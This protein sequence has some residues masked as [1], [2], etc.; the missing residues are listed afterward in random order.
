LVLTGFKNIEVID[1]DTIDVSNL[2]RQ[3]LFRGKHVGLPKST[4]AQEAVSHFNTD[5]F[6]EAYHGNVK[7]RQFGLKKL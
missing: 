2:N 4:V 5:A 6:V 7:E 1:L 3:F